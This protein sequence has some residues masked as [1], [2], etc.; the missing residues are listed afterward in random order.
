MPWLPP[1]YVAPIPGLDAADETAQRALAAANIAAADKGVRDDYPS[2][3]VRYVPAG[4]SELGA[5]DVLRALDLA[6]GEAFA[7]R[8]LVAEGECGNRDGPMFVI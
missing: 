5:D 6:V 2:G 8:E 3:A 7:C 1:L 4:G